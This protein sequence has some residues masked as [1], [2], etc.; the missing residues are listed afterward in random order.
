MPI[1]IEQFETQ[2]NKLQ[3]AFGT[4]KPAKIFE[5]W[6]K[7]FEHEDY[8]VF[9]NAMKRSQYGDRFP[10]W[11]IF[12]EQLKNAGGVAEGKE[13]K[14]CGDCHSGVVLF[15]DVNKNGQVTD[16]AANCAAC[17][18]NKSRGMANVFPKKLHI[19]AYGFLR[20]RRALEKDASSGVRIEEPKAT[21]YEEP[22][23]MEIVREVFGE[24]DEANERK[25]Y[26]SL[27]REEAR[28][29]YEF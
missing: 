4:V 19:D 22:Q 18:E 28:E 15:R 13:F 16:Q 6:F 10:T 1:T 20:T 25:R 5:E 14:G 17:S 11:E 9:L 27:K 23:P 3:A 24:E 12:K 7:E 29:N 2:F 26:G 21:R 8:F